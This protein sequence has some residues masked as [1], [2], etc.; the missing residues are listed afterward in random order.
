MF[1]FLINPFDLLKFSFLIIRISLFKFPKGFTYLQ[2]KEGVKRSNS[3]NFIFIITKIFL[4]LERK[5]L[6]IFIKENRKGKFSL[7]VK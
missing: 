6:I 7:M 4:K 3:V 1:I 5:I 2:L